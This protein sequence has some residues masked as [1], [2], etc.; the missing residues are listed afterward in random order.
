MT[1][2]HFL[3]CLLKIEAQL[4]KWRPD[5]VKINWVISNCLSNESSVINRKGNF[6]ATTQQ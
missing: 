1:S 5:A 3:V 2:L 6:K 4:N